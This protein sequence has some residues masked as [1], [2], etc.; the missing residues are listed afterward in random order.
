PL[1]FPAMGAPRVDAFALDLGWARRDPALRVAIDGRPIEG[2][3]SSVHL[4]AGQVVEAR[5][6]A[7]APMGVVLRPAGE[8]VFFRDPFPS[9]PLWGTP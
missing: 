5:N 8:R 4:T 6:E 3:A 7:S 9:V 1:A 2:A